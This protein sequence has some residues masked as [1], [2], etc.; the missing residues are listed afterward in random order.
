M[1]TILRNKP[2]QL[3][4]GVRNANDSGGPEDKSEE[5]ENIGLYFSLEATR[6]FVDMLQKPHHDNMRNL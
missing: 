1:A 3:I 6:V 5:T 4:V 2:F